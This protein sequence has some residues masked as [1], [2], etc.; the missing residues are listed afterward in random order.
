MPADYFEQIYGWYNRGGRENVI[1]YLRSYDLSAF[2]PKAS[3]PKTQAFFEI[4][5]ANRS[6][7]D[8]EL[9][10]T[11]ERMRFPDA[12]TLAMLTGNAEDEFSKWLGDRKNRRLVPHRLEAA[13]YQP[14][15][16]STADQGLWKVDGKRQTVYAKRVLDYREQCVA[17]NK[18]TLAKDAPERWL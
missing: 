9:M 5:D 7:E 6:P 10:D 3:P 16:N 14:V 17:A 1:A 11:L 2:D 8:A 4:V 12:L 13:G 18:L 15:R